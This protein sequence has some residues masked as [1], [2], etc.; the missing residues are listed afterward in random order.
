MRV[1]SCSCG[2]KF[3]TPWE[4]YMANDGTLT[5]D[6]KDEFVLWL[7]GHDTSSH[8]KMMSLVESSKTN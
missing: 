4:V 1:I 6:Q 2:D 7:S 5:P 8:V 3:Q